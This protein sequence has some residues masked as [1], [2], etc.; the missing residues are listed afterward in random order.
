M[1]NALR[2]YIVWHK[3]CEFVE[4]RGTTT[5]CVPEMHCASPKVA[6]NTRVRSASVVLRPSDYV[7][8]GCVL[9]GENNVRGVP[10]VDVDWS[11]MHEASSL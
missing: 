2:I 11:D 7:V 1:T 5:V 9:T 6:W 4:S 8:V 3:N 10:I